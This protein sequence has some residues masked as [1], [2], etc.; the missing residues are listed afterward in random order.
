MRSL[1][2]GTGSTVQYR[3]KIHAHRARDGG[4]GSY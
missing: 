2:C 4:R 3:V 1:V